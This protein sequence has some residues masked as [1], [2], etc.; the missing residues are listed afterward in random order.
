MD[1]YNVRKTEIQ[2]SVPQFF[3]C[4][5]NSTKTNND[6][7]NNIMFVVFSSNSRLFNVRFAKCQHTFI[8][9]PEPYE[10]EGKE[11]SR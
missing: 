7:K 2:A 8:Q 3:Y 1:I 4:N 6:N 10:Q 11:Y 9:F 5:V